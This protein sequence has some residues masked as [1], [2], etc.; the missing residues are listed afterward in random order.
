MQEVDER[1][2]RRS[3]VVVSDVVTSPTSSP[4]LIAVPTSVALRD[5]VALGKPRIALM[6]LITGGGTFALAAPVLDA[7][8]IMRGAFGLVG[9]ALLVMGAGALNMLI[10]RDVDTLMTRTKDRPLAAR[11]MA[12]STALTVGLL[13]CASALPL[14]AVFGNPLTVGLALLSLFLY[15]LVYTPMKRT[16]PWSLVVGAIPGAMPALMGG[17]LAAGKLE[18]A[19]LSMFAIGFL[20][21]LPLF[22]AISL[23]RE[24]EYTH[25]GHKVFPATLGLDTTKALIVGTTAPL[26]AM[27][28]ALWP[29]GLGGPVYALVATIIGVWFTFS[30]VA[31]YAPAV[32]TRADADVWARRVFIGSLVWQTVVF[33]ALAVDRVFS[34]IAL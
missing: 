8:T 20:W 10:E 33:G 12:P 19:G 16:S 32:A 3:V 4:A 15:V 13:L 25:A 28:V 18:I 5:I 23:Y 29:L 34:A 6:T 30:C 27:G 9:V 22:L 7:V 31:G 26:C 11:R 1:G 24:A 2:A 21:Q 17:T 14:L